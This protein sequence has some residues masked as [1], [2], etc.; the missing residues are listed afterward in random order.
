VIECREHAVRGGMRIPLYCEVAWIGAHGAEPY[1]R[2]RI[3][4]ID[5]EFWS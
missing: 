4:T 5:Y 3:S 1:W 2:G